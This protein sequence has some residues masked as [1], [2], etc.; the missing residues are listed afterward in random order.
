MR[1]IECRSL[2]FLV[3]SEFHYLNFPCPL[4]PEIS[5]FYILPEIERLFI[6]HIGDLLVRS[7]RD[8]PDGSETSQFGSQCSP[9]YAAVSPTAR[10]FM[11]FTSF[12]GSNSGKISAMSS[13]RSSCF[14]CLSR[15]LSIISSFS[16]AGDSSR[17]LLAPFIRLGGRA[18]SSDQR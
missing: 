8:K 2:I 3:G 13:S 11:C 14:S 9:P 12:A 17:R 18:H 1:S 15:I 6:F 5:E 4:P 16:W 10:F 7:S